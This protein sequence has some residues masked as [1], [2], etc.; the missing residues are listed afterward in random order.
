MQSLMTSSLYWTLYPVTCAL[1][2]SAGGRH[3]T[4]RPVGDRGSALKDRT[5]PGSETFR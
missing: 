1:D 4:S 5:A 3:L 2:V